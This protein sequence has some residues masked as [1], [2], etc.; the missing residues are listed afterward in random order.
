MLCDTMQEADRA[1]RF[2]D[3]IQPGMRTAADAISMVVF[4]KSQDWKGA[5]EVKGEEYSGFTSLM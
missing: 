5:R 3:S 4:A 1:G 2:A